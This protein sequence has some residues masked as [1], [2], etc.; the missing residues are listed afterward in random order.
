[1]GVGLAVRGVVLGLLGGALLTRYLQSLLYEVQPRDP[2]VFVTVAL[3]LGLV[4]LVA[5]SVPAWRA[6]T[7]DPLVAMRPD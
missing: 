4:A 3:G 2:V 1:M 5:V 6:T 7:V